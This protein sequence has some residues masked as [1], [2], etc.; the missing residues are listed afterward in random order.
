MGLAVNERVEDGGGNDSM[1]SSAMCDRSELVY[2]EL[3]RRL[4]N[5]E[6]Q[7][8]TQIS[9]SEMQMTPLNKCCHVFIYIHLRTKLCS[10]IH[11]AP[12]DRQNLSS[13]ILNVT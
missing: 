4:E 13:S 3:L 8:C 7:S 11:L 1:G 2:E 12:T 5:N 9:G 6:W 10:T